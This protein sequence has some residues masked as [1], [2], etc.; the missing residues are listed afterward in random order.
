M[1]SRALIVGCSGLELT[2]DEI[3]FF[4]EIEPWGFILF[5]R[6]VE[7]PRQVH[8]L[9][10]AL[11]DTVGLDH[12]PIL[13]DQ[14]GG[15]VQRMG[16]PHWPKYPSGSAYGRIHANDPLVRRELTRLGARL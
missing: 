8:A 14:E 13:I 10:D 16:P 9:C 3:A 6:N 7:N 1:T 15:R 5:K 11:R 12:A 2:P 4:R